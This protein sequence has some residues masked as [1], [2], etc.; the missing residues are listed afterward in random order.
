MSLHTLNG[1]N[2]SDGIAAESCAILFTSAETTG[3]TS[4]LRPSQKE[5]VPPKGI[6][7]PMKVTFQ[8]PMR[9]PQTRRILSP[10]IKKKPEISL[11]ADISDSLLVTACNAVSQ[12]TI[13]T[14][15]TSAK[16]KIQTEGKLVPDP[17]DD[18]TYLPTVNDVESFKSSDSLLNY[19]NS[20][21]QSLLEVL[22]GAE[23]QD[24]FSLSC[25][26]VW[27]PQTVT[28]NI[29]SEE[30]VCTTRNNFSLASLLHDDV[31][32]QI[33]NY[34]HATNLASNRACSPEPLP[35][36]YLQHSPRQKLGFH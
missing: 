26:S 30:A 35:M 33:L 23:K 19:S 2:I 15:I 14:E 18:L 3:R 5:N 34:D 10:D 11:I 13:T 28:K 24:G 29:P 16:E 7:K 27:W 25:D 12:P 36:L 4:I 20:Q 8:T 6:V 22:A 17:S 9:D 1:E 32:K 21:K 31:S